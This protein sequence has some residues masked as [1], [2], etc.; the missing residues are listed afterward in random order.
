MHKNK[1]LP[2]FKKSII[3]PLETYLKECKAQHVPEQ[4][5]VE[6]NQAE[7]HQ[8]TSD[9]IIKRND[10]PSSLKLK[11]FDQQFAR[12]E[13]GKK[14][15]NYSTVEKHP[16]STISHA[17]RD[18]QKID[19]IVTSFQIETQPFVRSILARYIERNKNS[20][21]WDDDSKELLINGQKREGTNI[22]KLLKYLMH[23]NIDENDVPIGLE[24]FK[25]VLLNVGVPLV[26]F[27]STPTSTKQ[28][29]AG[30]DKS[31]IEHQPENTTTNWREISLG[32]W[33]DE[34]RPDNK[35][36]YVEVD[37]EIQVKS[38]KKPPASSS[39]PKHAVDQFMGMRSDKKRA[40]HDTRK[41]LID[42]SPIAKRTRTADNTQNTT[43]SEPLWV[44]YKGKRRT[45]KPVSPSQQ[46]RGSDG[47]QP[48]NKTWIPISSSSK[49]K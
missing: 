43:M 19:N 18:Y 37:D 39:T 6:D 33:K 38:V 10:L 29:N 14:L 31:E 32:D 44:T 22:I 40:A 25:K 30:D 5:N 26:W 16:A 9:D 28:V 12:E 35:S 2:S 3:I 45:K 41:T 48:L 34:E 21:D 36:G 15:R 23:E 49:R 1:N 4:N 46:V 13:S 17:P 20:L 7:Y 24:E 47:Q 27:A 42:I 11:L 8:M